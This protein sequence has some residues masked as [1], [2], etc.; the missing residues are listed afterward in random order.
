[1]PTRTPPPPPDRTG[2][3]SN[4]TGTTPPGYT[5]A[6][7]GAPL[8]PDPN[9]SLL[10]AIG[11][12]TNAFPGLSNLASMYNLANY[13]TQAGE[14]AGTPGFDS[15]LANLHGQVP[16]DVIN[17]LQQGAAER[18]IGTGQSFGDSPNANAAYMRALGLNSEQLQAEGQQQYGNLLGHFPMAAPFNM[19]AFMNTPDAIQSAN[20]A[21]NVSAA[22]PNPQQA[23]L[24]EQQALL[25]AIAAGKGSVPGAGNV[26]GITL[27][28]VSG[29]LT[30]P[31]GQTVGSGP[32]TT[33]NRGTNP[34]IDPSLN[35]YLDS[36]LNPSTQ[37]RP[38]DAIQQGVGPASTPWN[39][40]GT[41]PNVSSFLNTL[42]GTPGYGDSNVLGIGLNPTLNAQF[43][44][45][46]GQDTNTQPW[47]TD[48]WNQGSSVNDSSVLG[49]GLD[50][51]LTAL[52]G[53]S[54]PVVG[55]G[56]PIDWWNQATP[57]DRSNVDPSQYLPDYA[58]MPYEDPAYFE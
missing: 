10:Q 31:P 8:I 17:Q 30:A 12:D 24:A 49:A 38:P 56:L 43:G 36:L 4:L 1:M 5:P 51:Q 20:T 40:G 25:A 28:S 22:A 2:I 57:M 46:P 15:V 26:P 18:G 54:N 48:W 41:S 47:S 45:A 55:G 44:T 6:Y 39:L 14:V 58:M 42:F 16:Q 35:S 19:S 37:G 7:G 27:P 3:P 34:S 32:S 50:P 53:G 11:G 9:A 29:S 13:N 52:L 21:A 33:V 23:A